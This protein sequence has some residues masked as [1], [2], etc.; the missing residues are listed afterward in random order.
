MALKSGQQVKS[1]NKAV[2]CYDFIKDFVRIG[3]WNTD[4]SKAMNADTTDESNVWGESNF[5]VDS[6]KPS[7]DVNPY[8]VYEGDSLAEYIEAGTRQAKTGDYWEGYVVEVTVDDE[9]TIV[10]AYKYPCVLEPTASGW[11]S[12]NYWHEFTL[13]YL[14]GGESVTGTISKSSDGRNQIFTITE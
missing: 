5:S 9:G 8:K 3:K 13:H 1:K 2:F 14:G 11:D 12:G 6:L 10:D 4:M 7:M